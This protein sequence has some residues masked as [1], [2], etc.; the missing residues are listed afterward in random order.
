[1]IFLLPQAVKWLFSFAGSRL[2]QQSHRTYIDA[3][4][5][6]RQ[7]QHMPA[8]SVRNPM[9]ALLLFAFGLQASAQESDTTRPLQEVVVEA[10]NQ[11]RRLRDLPASVHYVGPSVLQRFSP[12]SLVP[13]VN[14]AP[15]VRMEERSPGSY[16]LNIRGSALRS[17]F[18]V[19]N[20]KVYFNDIPIT[21]P[22]GHTYLNQLGFYNLHHLEIIKGPGSSVYGAGTGGVVLAESMGAEE[23]PGLFA[24]YATGSY[25]LHNV[26]GRVIS[27]NERFRSKAGI[28]HQ[29]SEGYRRHSSLRRDVL[30]WSGDFRPDERRRIKT[31]FLYGDL[32]YETPGALTE[33]EYAADPAAARPGNAFFPGA[34][35]AG[36]SI[37]QQQLIA[38]ISYEQ[39]LR[40]RLSVKTVAYG[41]FTELRNPTVQNYGRS[42]EPHGGARSTFSWT[43]P[44]R[45]GQWR[46][47]AGGEWQEGYTTVDI[48][49]NRGGVADTLRNSDEIRNRQSLFFLQSVLDLGNWTLTAGSSLNLLRVR[50]QRFNPGTQGP[51]Q[52]QFRQWAPRLALLRR[53]GMV[54]A[55]ASYARGFSPPTTAELLPTGGAINA[56]LNA[57]LGDNYEAG[58]KGILG[59]GFQFD[60]TAF[61]FA[62][63]NTIVQRRTAGGGDFFVNAGRTRQ[64]GVETALRYDFREKSWLP[65]AGGLWLSHTWHRFRYADFRQTELDYSGKALPGIAPHTIA[66]G[67]DLWLKKRLFFTLTYY[68]SDRLPVNDANTVYA[69]AY[70]LVGA[71]AGIQQIR[72]KRFRLKLFVGA[73]DLLDERYTLGP[74]VNGFGGRFFNAAP[75][76]NFYASIVVESLFRPAERTGAQ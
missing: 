13:A 19:R 24:E 39:R 28:Q 6:Q 75:R 29:Q 68:Y 16:R 59:R 25:G 1:M 65:A 46:L 7:N 69:G 4:T 48:F 49:Q 12:V 53:F 55:W 22:G 40:E 2:Q 11:N 44:L 60:I 5:T 42:T 45:Q 41:Q 18:G 14:T 3:Q 51:Q 63:R 26:Y 30:S 67:A 61:S 20:V 74:D 71:K 38:G 37:R 34:E 8:P 21:D 31:T 57:E 50:F 15:G 62:L 70:H 33:A 32:S 47:D 64:R 35:A 27:G 17:P 54:S 66:A 10:F 43:Q 73:D 58:L 72:N 76:R 52:Q 23:R 36:A 9:P 56:G